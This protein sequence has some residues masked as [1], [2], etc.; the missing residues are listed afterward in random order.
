MVIHTFFKV[1]AS[2]PTA[3]TILLNQVEIAL[4]LGSGEIPRQRA[5]RKYQGITHISST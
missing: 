2:S 5:S 3:E 4:K 1:F